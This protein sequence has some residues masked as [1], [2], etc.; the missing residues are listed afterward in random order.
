M[1]GRGSATGGA[2]LA[3]AVVLWA[4][5]AY[6]IYC[7]FQTPTAVDE[8]AN[9]AGMHFQS[10]NFMLGL[11]CAIVGTLFGCTAAIVAEIARRRD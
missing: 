4:I 3:I 9:M 5:A 1:E 10:L 7:G 11:G 8:V 2:L 6:L